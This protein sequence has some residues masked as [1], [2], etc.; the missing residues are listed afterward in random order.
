MGEALWTSRLRWRIR[1]ATLWPT[2]VLA[3]AVDA[4]L[5]DV[6]PIS[7]DDGPGLFAT[8]ILAGILNLIVVAVAAPL[9]GRLLRR[10]RPGMPRVV[11][12]DVAGTALV[13]LV[14]AVVALLGVLHRP[15]VH[16]ADVDF[17]A[18]ANAARRFV[19]AHAPREFRP[20]VD[21]MNTWKQGPTLY[22]TCAAGPDPR[23]WYCLL[24]DTKP[25]P[26]TIVR[27]RDQRP[28]ALAMGRG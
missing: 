20:G 19:L 9:C 26:P 7:G 12:T 17:T 1:G 10:R 18:Q 14:T 2:F 22:R 24:I 27:D 3:V 15:A 23:R 4:V 5:L 28:N 21:R 16:A 8:I 25:F 6:L 11:A 13:V